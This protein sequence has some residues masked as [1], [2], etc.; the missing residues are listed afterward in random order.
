M[1][2]IYICIHTMYKCV[3]SARVCMCLCMKKCQNAKLKQINTE[4]TDLVFMHFSHSS[5]LAWRI[6]GTGVPGGLPS[7][8]SHRVGYD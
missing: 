6:P 3:Q 2:N 5:V 4:V 8:G 7:M 1:E